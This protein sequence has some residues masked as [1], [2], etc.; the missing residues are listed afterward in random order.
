MKHRLGYKAAV[1]GVFNSMGC[2]IVGVEG[3]IGILDNDICGCQHKC[4]LCG[5]KEV[6]RF[7]AVVN[8][9]YCIICNQVFGII[10]RAIAAD[11]GDC[12]HSRGR[13]SVVCNCVGGICPEK[14][15][16]EPAEELHG[17]D[18]P[19]GRGCFAEKRDDIA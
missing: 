2:G 11:S 13:E 3:A 9:Y 4:P 1:R 5:S 17:S 18:R 16:C 14:Q 10:V 7:L 19:E 6:T 8:Q 12:F 15:E